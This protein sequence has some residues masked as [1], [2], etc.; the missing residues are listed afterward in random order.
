M[1]LLPNRGRDHAP[2][3]GTLPQEED[4]YRQ[5]QPHD[6]SCLNHVR[7]EG[8]PLI[9]ELNGDLKGLKVWLGRKVD[10]RR[11]VIVP[12]KHKVK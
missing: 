10:E 11:E 4:D 1:V 9:V 6:R 2:H 7:F 12:G 8:I 5:C 3:E